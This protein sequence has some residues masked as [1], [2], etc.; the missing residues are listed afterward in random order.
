M[1]ISFIT[2]LAVTLLPQ[3]LSP[4]T[5]TVSPLPMAMST[6]STAC[7]QPSSVLV[8]DQQLRAAGQRD[9]D[10]HALAHATRELVRVVVHA[11]VGRRDVHQ[12]EHLDGAFERRLPGQPLV[13]AHALGDLLAHGEHRVQARHRFLEDDGDLFGPDLPHLLGPQRHEIA[14]LP[15]HAAG[16]DLARR[17]VDQLHHRLGGDALAAAAL[18][19]HADRLALADGDVD[20]VDG[21]Q[22]AVVGLEVGLQTLDLEQRHVIREPGGGRARRA[23]RRR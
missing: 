1:S 11:L 8:G 13:Q 10:H 2:V 15:Q 21:V 19:D 6:P 12:L 4:T 16:H 18:A 17:H 14:A 7:S 3:P 20:A 22:P 23:A 9:G 5:Q